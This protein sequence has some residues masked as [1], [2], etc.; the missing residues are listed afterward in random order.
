MADTLLHRGPDQGGVWTDASAGVGLGFRRLSIVD[1]SAVRP[2]A[3]GLGLGPL[4]HLLQ[5]RDLQRRGDARQAR[6]PRQGLSGTLRHR[7]AAGGLR[8]MGPGANALRS[9]RHVRHRPLGPAGARALPDPRPAGQEAALLVAAGR[10]PALRLR[11]AGAEGPPQ[12]R[13][14]DRPRRARRVRAP[15]LFPASAH[16]STGACAS[17][18]PGAT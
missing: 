6:G 11:A 14:R 3:H 15:G 10:P 8:R 13:G 12:V 16:R 2:P 17:S 18:S 7:G 5:R 9:R 4:R 1:L